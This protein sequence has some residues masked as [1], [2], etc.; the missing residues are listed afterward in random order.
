[1][2]KEKKGLAESAINIILN[3]L[4][5]IFGLILLITI[6]NNIQTKIFKN[7]YSSFFGY[8]VFEVQ[9]GSMADTIN[10]GD[11]IIVKYQRA[12]NL[13]DIITYEQ[14]GNFVTHRVVEVYKETLVTKGDFNNT[15]DDPISRK[16]VV[17]KVVKILPNFGIVRKTLFNPFVLLTI[18]ITLYFAGNILKD[19]K[20]QK[21]IDSKENTMKGERVTMKDLINKIINKL[22]KNKFDRV[23]DSPRIEKE[24]VSKKDEEN[25][26]VNKIESDKVVEEN[27]LPI[28]EKEETQDNPQNSS[29]ED[30]E[31]TMFFRMVSVDQEEIDGIYSETSKPRKKTSNVS[32]L[33]T[34]EEMPREE[35]N[36]SEIK[37]ELELINKRRKKFRNI[38]EKVIYI[39]TT[40]LDEI[41]D[42]LNQREAPKTNEKSI[43][44]AFLDT[45]IDC[46]Y[47][48]YCGNVNAEYNNKNMI[49]KVNGVIIE[50][51]EKLI[52]SYQKSDSKYTEKVKKYEKLYTL[53]AQLEQAFLVDED[54]QT[55]RES[56]KNK[57]VR[58]L[59][60]NAYSESMLK[61]IVQ[62]IVRT[63]K[64]YSSIIK[65]SFEKLDTNMF[66]LDLDNAISKAKK[67]YA[68]EL[69]HN[70]NFSK[71]Y[72][73]YIVDKTYQEGV[74]AE[75]KIYVLLTLLMRQI[76]IDILNADFNK[77]YLLCLPESLYSKEKK[78]LNLIKFFEDEYAKN[79]IIML[80]EYAELSENSKLIKDS[81]KNGYHFAVDLEN[82]EKIKNKDRGAIEL[83]DYIFM[84]RRSR[85]K[86][87]VLTTLSEE[88]N[89]K[90][91]YVDI[92]NK[93]KNGWGN[94]R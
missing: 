23:E 90:V 25:L 36:E 41:I 27:N 28:I 37:K 45:Y 67:L 43:R 34:E 92:A 65:Y 22:R 10:P 13:K 78:F 4:I 53:L 69:K 68:A 57:I 91:L 60:N 54:L 70:I 20:K 7:S 50:F 58:H 72:S 16:Q 81:I 14:D 73:D 71:V 30:L 85:E 33:I 49:S 29:E 94:E 79:S 5:T 93:V 48:N 1:M 32:K 17:G 38:L 31:K 74:V 40:E 76:S 24:A 84:G 87:A 55:K 52:K 2:T 46:K 44:K 89:E 56:Y 26:I 62:D 11:W 9:T 86:K 75:D 39:K 6:Y 82:V 12:I 19:K 63:Q 66:E 80:V 35:V 64:K 47:Y 51:S 8:S 83:M 15:K 21:S 77:K 88:A 18:I 61:K 42:I 3:I 59:G